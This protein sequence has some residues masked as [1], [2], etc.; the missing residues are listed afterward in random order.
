MI[1][2]VDAAG[3]DHYPK[4]PVLGALAAIKEFERL[5]ILLVGPKKLVQ[6]E[7]SKYSFDQDRIQVVD[8]PEIVEMTD[9]AS[10]ALKQKPNSS[11]A[12][13][14]SM[15]KQGQ[16]HGFVSA[17]NTGALLAASMFI[18]GK[19]EGISRPTIA[20]YYPSLEG[21]RLIIDA[22]ANLEIKPD[23]ALQ[24]AL[25]GQVYAKEIMGIEQPRVGLLNVGEEEGKGTEL[26]KEIY[27]ALKQI[28][29]F[30]GN[31]EGRDILIPK[32]DIFITDGYIGNVVL[33]LGE[34][35]PGILKTLVGQR[36]QQ[37]KGTPEMM[38][39]VQQILTESLAPFDYER[40][41]G[42]PFLGV[43]GTSVVGHG[44]SSPTAIKN[45]IKVA[46]DCVEHSINDKIIASIN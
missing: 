46:M 2:A 19:L 44:G 43:N 3:G 8:S 27:G 13:G 23:M 45:M 41:G 24:F 34:S 16:C 42:L 29:S 1:I 38:S 7:L 6:N 11:I 26:L 30:I 31:V 37:S 25:M 20:T 15:H 33:K 12:K 14:I 21:F 10:A 22:G 28:P 18:L 17:G 40:V 36:L 9:S 39:F 5:T 32:A 35:L 4:N